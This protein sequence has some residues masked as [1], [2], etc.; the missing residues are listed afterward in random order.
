M[1]LLVSFSPE[2]SN[3]VCVDSITKQLF[4]GF[5]CAFYYGKTK[6]VF[7]YVCSIG[8]ICCVESTVTWENFV[9]QLIA[10]ETF[11][12]HLVILPFN[13]VTYSFSKCHFVHFHH[14]DFSLHRFSLGEWINLIKEFQKIESYGNY[15]AILNIETTISTLL[16]LCLTIKTKSI[17]KKRIITQF[18]LFT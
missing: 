13:R 6:H 4:Y 14:F 12:F 17:Y 8:G 11:H 3:L 10:F 9:K 16:L 2:M 5:V 1:N 18:I 15:L 7:K